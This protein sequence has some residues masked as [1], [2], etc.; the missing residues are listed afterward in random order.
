MF[1]DDEQADI[2]KTTIAVSNNIFIM[3]TILSNSDIYVEWRLWKDRVGDY[4]KEVSL[5]QGAEWVS[6]F[7]HIITNIK[8]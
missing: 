6:G 4:L 2:V 7:S 5:S 8:P 1:D 3:P